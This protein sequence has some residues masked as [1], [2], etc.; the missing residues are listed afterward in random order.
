MIT[1]YARDEGKLKVQM[2]MPGKPFP[3]GAI[4]VDAERPSLEEIALLQQ[5]LGFELPS[6]E[7]RERNFTLS[8]MFKS[9]GVTYM[10]A[11]IIT[12]T[13]GPYPE[14][15]PIKFILTEDTLLT[16]RDIQ[17]TSFENFAVRLA[18]STKNFESGPE[19]LHGLL[20]E[21]VLRVS[22]NADKVV[23]DLDKLSHRIFDPYELGEENEYSEMSMKSVLRKLGTVADLN[24]Q[25]HESLHSISRMI[26]FFKEQQTDNQYLARKLDVLAGDVKE[27][28]K[29][30][31]FQSDK[32][33]FQLDAALGMIN[34][35]QNLNMKILSTFTVFLMPP[36]LIGSIYG[37]NFH[38]MPELS[39]PWGY[40]LA[41]GLMITSAAAPY[42]YFRKRRWL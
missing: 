40:P 27:L 28:S 31:G 22:F 14:I 7:E 24:S 34:V 39:Q 8:R 9:D 29:Q 13:L 32:I 33:T 12:K 23:D 42:L 25:I 30:T 2:W 16:V 37:M 18:G 20:E 36:T 3:T 6:K 21:I 10:V 11:T 17:P 1:I 19:A 26:A 41:L 5:G 15:R 35:E 4:W 38:F